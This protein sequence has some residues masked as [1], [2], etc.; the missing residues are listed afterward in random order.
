VG[1]HAGGIDAEVGEFLRR[2]RLFFVATAPLAAA[3]RVNLSPRG[4]DS[5]RILDARTVAWLDLTGSGIETVAHLRENGRIVLMFC[6]FEGPGRIV[7]LHG[8]GEVLE[9]GGS[10]FD[11]LSALFPDL[12]GARCVVRDRRSPDA[13]RGGA[14]GTGRIV[15][16][17]GARGTARL[18]RR[19]EPLEPRRAAGAP[20]LVPEPEVPSP[21]RERIEDVED[22]GGLLTAAGP[23][24]PGPA[25]AVGVALER[26]E[27][28]PVHD[29][30]PVAREG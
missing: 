12:P 21:G 30:H 23:G 15:P 26:L 4:L 10:G 16:P 24:E 13:V 18:P 20:G 5:F 11:D 8:R 27:S 14:D 7:R 6:A 1:E 2:Q 25:G 9:P 22:V 19:E 3:G 29:V 17:A 28:R